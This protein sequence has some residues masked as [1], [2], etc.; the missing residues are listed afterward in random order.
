MLKPQTYWI[1]SFDGLIHLDHIGRF[2]TL[3]KDFQEIC[4]AINLPQITLP[5]RIKGTGENYREYYDSES[6][7]IV[8]TVYQEEIKMFNY[9]FDSTP[10]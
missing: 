6:I 5:H 10:E 1:K 2:E 3:A 4:K 9:S 8:S 7:D